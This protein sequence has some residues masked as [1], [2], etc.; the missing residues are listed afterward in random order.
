MKIRVH[1]ESRLIIYECET[2]YNT[3]SDIHASLTLAGGNHQSDQ[4]AFL[5][6]IIHVTPHGCSYLIPFHYAQAT[7]N[8]TSALFLRGLP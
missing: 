3:P 1:I 7:E 6:V 4:F 2:L 8:L 5:I